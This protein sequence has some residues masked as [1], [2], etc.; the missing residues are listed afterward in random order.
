MRYLLGGLEGL[1]AGYVSLDSSR[2]WLVYW[3]VH[4]LDLLGAPLPE[5]VKKRVVGTF[6]VALGPRDSL[7]PQLP[8][9]LPCKALVKLCHLQ[10]FCTVCGLGTCDTD[11]LGRCVHVEG[12]YGGGPGQV[13]PL[14]CGASV[15]FAPTPR[16]RFV[17]THT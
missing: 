5:D 2:T 3:S 10:W 6:S 7:R 4:A 17:L 11:F 14:G 8:T 13:S 16:P 12:G 9:N 15:P 1:P